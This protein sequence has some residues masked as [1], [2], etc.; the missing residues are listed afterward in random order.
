MGGRWRFMSNWI[1]LFGLALLTAATALSAQLPTIT[2]PLSVPPPP[3]PPPLSAPAVAAIVPP[4]VGGSFV[5]IYSFL[6]VR[7]EEFSPK[8]LQQLDDDLK[9][10]FS[11]AQVRVKSL[12]F[13][14]S[15]TGQFY[16]T[17]NTG[18]GSTLIPVERTIKENE[19]D[20]HSEGANFRLIIFPS[21]FTVSGAWRF[22]DIRCLL[23]DVTD[24]RTRWTYIYHG[25]HLVIWKESEN[26]AAR[27]KKILDAMFADMRAR[28]LLN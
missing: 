11:V 5:Y 1:K 28:G 6:D 13:R 27:S 14:N 10:R 20:E 9:A 12:S 17:E 22:Y 8:V 7:Q 21:N 2:V 25:S 4:Q 15:S 26:A 24:N 3:A 16:S 19:A 18:S 23:I